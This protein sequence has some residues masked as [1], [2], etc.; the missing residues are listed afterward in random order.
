MDEILEFRLEKESMRHEK[1]RCWIITL[2]S[3]FGP[4]DDMDHQTRSKLEVFEDGR[5]LGPPHA[6]HNR[7]RV[8][9]SGLYSHWGRQLYFSSSDNTAPDNNGRCYVVRGPHCLDPV[10]EEAIAV[11]GEAVEPPLFPRLA[12]LER[13]LSNVSPSRDLLHDPAGGTLQERLRLLEAKVEYLLDELYTAKSQL[14]H[15][16]PG[17]PSIERLRRYQLESFDFQWKRLPYH[18]AFLTNPAWRSTAADDVCARLGLPR[19]WFAGKTILDCGCGPG[20]H[21]WTFGSLGAQ[22]IAFDM[23]DNGLEAAREECKNLP[24]VTID[25]RNILEP[26]P[27][28]RNFDLVWSYGV[29]H[30]TG[31]TMRAVENIA[32]HVRSGGFI[33][34]MVYPEP[35]RT[36]GDSY[37]YYHEVDVLRRMIRH[38]SLEQKA[39]LLTK[40]QGERWALSWFDAISSEINDLYT[41]EELA[42]ML[43]TLGFVN[44]VRTMPQ[45]HS[46]NVVATKAS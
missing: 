18:D 10:P 25:K 26:L 22:V 45:E 14:R 7:I 2:P 28:D 6:D 32:S 36:N 43:R 27:Y 35:E 11:E 30:C 41:F 34:L 24:N 40:I 29:V 39:E 31:D 8:N 44:V 42:E 20:R 46:L 13:E 3:E 12:A 21:T 17:V 37:R 23:S 33:Y 38:L 15:L 1:G 16:L 19:E 9:G 4:G 5:Q